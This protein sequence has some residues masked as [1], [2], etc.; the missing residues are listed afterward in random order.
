MTEPNF[1]PKEGILKKEMNL[2]SKATEPDPPAALS[3]DQGV[4]WRRVAAIL[5][6]RGTFEAAETAL[7]DYIRCWGR[8]QQC[9]ADIERRGVLVQG[10]RG[11]VKNPACQL[12]REYRAALLAW[13]R[14]LSLTKAPP[15]LRGLTRGCAL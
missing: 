11:M 8:L 2:L 3:A 6:R 15:P 4:E 5:R 1:C 14:E 12:A 13:S 10:D 7:R 9:E